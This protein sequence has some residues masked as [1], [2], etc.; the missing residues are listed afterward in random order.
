MKKFYMFLMLLM[1]SLSL[2]ACGSS[3]STSKKEDKKQRQDNNK[4]EKSKTHSEEVEY[5]FIDGQYIYIKE[6]E[7]YGYTS[8]GNIYYRKKNDFTTSSNMTSSVPTEKK[9]NLK[10]EEIAIDL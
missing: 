8:D 9:E 6:G 3:E 1:L 2:V 5:K 7:D 10:Q 4:S